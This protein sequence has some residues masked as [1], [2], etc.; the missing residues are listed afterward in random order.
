MEEDK[1]EIYLDYHATTP[2]LPEV[3]E[4]MSPYFCNHFG[5]ANSSHRWGWKD[6]AA[7]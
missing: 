2:V 4:A 6:H 1:K 7:G 5:N 3:M